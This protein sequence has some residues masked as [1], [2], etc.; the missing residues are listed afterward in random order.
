MVHKNLQDTLELIPPEKLVM[1]I[2]N[3]AYDWP[4]IPHQTPS[5]ASISFQQA[6]VT[7]KESD[8]AIYFDEDEQNPTYSYVDENRVGHEVWL[9]DAATAYNEMRAAE[10]SQVRGTALWRLGS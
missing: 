1:G 2:A 9:L 4:V 8:T 6:L 5:G 7:A 10:R 3:Y